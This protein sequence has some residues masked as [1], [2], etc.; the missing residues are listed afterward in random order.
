MKP[1]TFLNHNKPKHWTCI[2]DVMICAC[3][4]DDVIDTFCDLTN[5]KDILASVLVS[6]WWHK[7]RHSHHNSDT[8]FCVCEIMRFVKSLCSIMPI[9]HFEKTIVVNGKCQNFVSIQLSTAV[10]SYPQLAISIL[11]RNNVDHCRLVFLS[12][13]SMELQD[14]SRGC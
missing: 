1:I 10:N 3:P 9:Q 7:T 5:Q 6:C 2:R 4:R 11:C 14:S 12:Q 13:G 8:F